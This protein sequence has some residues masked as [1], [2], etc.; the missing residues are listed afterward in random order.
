MKKRILGI[1]LVALSITTFGSMAQSVATT[2]A[3][4]TEQVAKDKAVK[5][6]GKNFKKDGKKADVTR[7]QKADPFRGMNLTDAQ[8]SQLE[9]LKAK[10]MAK[11]QEAKAKSEE[12]KKEA[13]AKKMERD[14]LKG[15]AREAERREYFEQV[16]AIVG[17]DNYEIFLE[18]QV[19]TQDAPKTRPAK[20]FKKGDRKDFKKG[21]RKDFKKGERKEMK[22]VNKAEAQ[23]K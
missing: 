11:R 15:A 18:N 3:Q 6:D 5:V 7:R 21:D 8:K 16:K 19:V 10:R 13:R 22:A 1:A 12:A 14:S 2:A 9:E 4:K 17:P 23:Q 20:D